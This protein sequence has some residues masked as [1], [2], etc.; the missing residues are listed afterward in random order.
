M[1]NSDVIA[2]QLL[3]ARRWTAQLRQQFTAALE[4][5]RKTAQPVEPMVR[6]GH[7]VIIRFRREGK[8]YAAIGIRRHPLHFIVSWFVTGSRA[9][10]APLYTWEALLTEIIGESNWSTITE[11]VPAERCDPRETVEDYHGK[12]TNEGPFIR[13]APEYGEHD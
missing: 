9:S 10:Q 2:E 4:A 5:E 7:P 1:K 6:F 3:E 8:T 13:P 11:M 12:A